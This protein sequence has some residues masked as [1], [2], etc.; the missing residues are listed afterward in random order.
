MEKK[1]TMGTRKKSRVTGITP[2]AN[3]RFDTTAAVTPR[4][5]PWEIERLSPAS[6]VVEPPPAASRSDVSGYCGTA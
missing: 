4:K 2:A 6:M 5:R 1:K 3:W